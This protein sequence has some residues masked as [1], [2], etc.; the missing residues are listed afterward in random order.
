MQCTNVQKISSQHHSV[1]HTFTNYRKT[2][3]VC[4]A[5][6]E[7]VDQMLSM[8]LTNHM[9]VGGFLGCLLDNVLP[10]D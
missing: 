6:S 1:M 9:F 3:E 7:H 8:L 2:H 10:G 5:G 4:C